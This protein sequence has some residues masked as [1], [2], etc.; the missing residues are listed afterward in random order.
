MASESG[1]FRKGFLLGCLA[2]AGVMVWN[3]PQPGWRT[4]EQMLELAEGMLFRVIDMPKTANGNHAGT[5]PCTPEGI[6]APTTMRFETRETTDAGL[7]IG[8][9]APGDPTVAQEMR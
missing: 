7:E 4:R 3:A 2:G 6:P 9:D 5:I 8:L 1:A